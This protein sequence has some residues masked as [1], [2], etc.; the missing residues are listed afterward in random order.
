M[1]L[2]AG[3]KVIGIWIQLSALFIRQASHNYGSLK[4]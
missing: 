1:W 4:Y 3:Q 2:G